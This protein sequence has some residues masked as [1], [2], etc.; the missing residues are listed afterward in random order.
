[1]EGV[2][3]ESDWFAPLERHRSRR[4][5]AVPTITVLMGPTGASEWL[6]RRWH[7]A[8][9][10]VLV[11]AAR[12]AEVVAQWLGRSPALEQIQ[13]S[14]LE[15]IAGVEEV[16][17]DELS[18][19][20]AGRSPAQLEAL[21]SRVALQIGVGVDWVRRVLGLPASAPQRDLES[22]DGLAR[23]LALTGKV[24][25]LLVRSAS[26][27]ESLVEVA[28]TL[29]TIAEWAPQADVALALDE[30]G[31]RLLRSSAP[32]RVSTALMEGLVVL[33]PHTRNAPQLGAGPSRSPAGPASPASARAIEYDP[34]QLARSQAELSL[35]E[36]LERRPQTRGLFRLNRVVEGGT[37]GRG[38]ELD[39]S[40]ETLKIA[41][42]VDGYHHFRDADAY[43][44]DRRKDVRLQELGYLVV[45]ILASD[46][47]SAPEHVLESIDSVIEGRRRRQS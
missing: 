32:Q 5:Q 36:W 35:F 10:V 41:I 17:R 8:S 40:C 24:P 7:C 6:W 39:L 19:V 27:A 21:A 15:A 28:T 4:L 11:T 14:L 37:K 45:R 16:S 46:I 23:L 43:R 33:R 3:S 20:L 31:L 42:E 12:R 25:P 29:Y 1:M 13:R 38:M 2:A 26:D 47:D 44:R 9:P 22:H 18:S 34:E 30:R